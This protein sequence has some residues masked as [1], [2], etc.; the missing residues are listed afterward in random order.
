MTRIDGIIAAGLGIASSIFTD[1]NNKFG[2]HLPSYTPANGNAPSIPSTPYPNPISP[3]P[4]KPNPTISPVDL[5]PA[6]PVATPT[7]YKPLPSNPGTGRTAGSPEYKWLYQYPLPIPDVAQP[8]FTEMVNGIPIE[9]YETTIEPFQQ[10]VYPNLG[11]A[12]LIGY[13]L[14]TLPHPD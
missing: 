13:G 9:Y 5:G 1:I 2:P 10:Q 14:Y 4:S 6:R 11:P 8:M 3:A 7:P 12:N